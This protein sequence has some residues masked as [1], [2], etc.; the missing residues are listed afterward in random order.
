M[1][2]STTSVLPAI[3]SG[4]CAHKF[5]EASKVTGPAE[6]LI[7]LLLWTGTEGKT[8][9]NMQTKKGVYVK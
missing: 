5:G 3:S 1:H 9:F 2:L 8:S 6:E 7:I 4:Q